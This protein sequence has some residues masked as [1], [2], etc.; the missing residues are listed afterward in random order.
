MVHP[1]DLLL[2][3]CATILLWF[4]SSSA[5][6]HLARLHFFCS[7][8]P[9]LRI[10]VVFLQQYTLLGLSEGDVVLALDV[11]VPQFASYTIKLKEAG[12]RDVF[13][14]ARRGETT[15]SVKLRFWTRSVVRRPSTTA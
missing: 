12:E 5:V 13:L 10:Y 8:L 9:P 15:F 7:P 11:E 3:H 14:L 4:I 2:R 6:A 1:L